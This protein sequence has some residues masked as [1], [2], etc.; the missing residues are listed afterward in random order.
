MFNRSV[1][2]FRDVTRFCTQSALPVGAVTNNTLTITYSV[3][4]LRGDPIDGVL[5][6]A[7]LQSGVT[8]QSAVP[9]QDQSGQQLVFSLVRIPPLSLDAATAEGALE[10]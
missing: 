10:C 9:M 6:T 7:S 4:N 2:W 1:G 5:L 8:F 3:F